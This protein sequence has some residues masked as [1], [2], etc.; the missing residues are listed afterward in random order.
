MWQFVGRDDFGPHLRAQLIGHRAMHL[1]VT[2]AITICSEHAITHANN[3]HSRSHTDDG[4][5]DLQHCQQRV[6][7]RLL[8]QIAPRQKLV[9]FRRLQRVLT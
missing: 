2:H 5:H 6:L 7:A 3:V 4:A 8:R 1:R 9:E